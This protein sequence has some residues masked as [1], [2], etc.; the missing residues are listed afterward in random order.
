[1]ST[2]TTAQLAYNIK[3]VAVGDG[4][5]GKT[6]LLVSYTTNTFENDYKPTVCVLSYPPSPSPFLTLVLSLCSMQVFDNYSSTVLVDG[7]VT[8]LSLWDTAG[9][10]DYDQFR[11]LS[12]PQ[13][14]VFI[15]C[16]SVISPT[17]FKNMKNKWIAELNNH[18]PGVPILLVGTKSDLRT[19]ETFQK[20]HGLNASSFVK[21]DDAQAFAT[22]IGALGCIECSAVTQDNLK[23]VF[24]TA[25]RAAIKR[26]DSKGRDESKAGC[27]IIL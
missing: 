10:E 15:V 27:C 1:M 17:S 24:D 18:A 25:I 21:F 8:N 20:A 7:T 19:D 3:A 12:Y 11:P 9:Q 26:Q 13:T 5:V 2:K 14:D 6:S 22:E 16:Y 4:A 23:P